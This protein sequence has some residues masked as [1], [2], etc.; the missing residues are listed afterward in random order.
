MGTTERS[1]IDGKCWPSE[2]VKM[3]GILLHTS[4]CVWMAHNTDDRILSHDARLE[5]VT[6]LCKIMR[7]CLLRPEIFN[8]AL[9]GHHHLRRIL[10]GAGNF[11]LQKV[12]RVNLKFNTNSP[13]ILLK[14]PIKHKVSFSI[15]FIRNCLYSQLKV[16]AIRYLG[17]MI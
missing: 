4:R 6:D 16:I 17:L 7:W 3:R 2:Y 14:L 13:D 15:N 12:C 8:E 5:T 11:N 9:V 1:N 10:L